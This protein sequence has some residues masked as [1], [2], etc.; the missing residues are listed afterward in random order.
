[1]TAAAA[2]LAEGAE[3]GAVEAFGRLHGNATL[4]HS[5]A[6]ALNAAVTAWVQQLRVALTAKLEAAA[7]AIFFPFILLAVEAC[8]TVHQLACF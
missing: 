4:P 8:I 1:M 3:Y 5:H 7:E 6:D 2:A